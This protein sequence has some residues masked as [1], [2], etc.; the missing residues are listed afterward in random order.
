M[1]SNEVHSRG[2]IKSISFFLTSHLIYQQV[3]RILGKNPWI[4]YFALGADTGTAIEQEAPQHRRQRVGSIQAFYRLHWQTQG[5][6]HA[7]GP[8]PI[9][10]PPAAA[11]VCEIPSFSPL[12]LGGPRQAEP[13][14]H[15]ESTCSHGT[16]QAV[17]TVNLQLNSVPGV[18]ERQN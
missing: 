10:T 2:E 15:A 11:S 5:I 18:A 4:K 12:F 3:N 8:G 7:L 1:Q 9:P 14:R 16:A 13:T 6:N 17:E